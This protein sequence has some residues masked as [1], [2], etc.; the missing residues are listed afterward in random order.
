MDK[1]NDK[2]RSSN[3]LL[4]ALISFLVA[5]ATFVGTTLIKDYREKM[6]VERYA[7]FLE[8]KFEIQIDRKWQNYRDD[9]TFLEEERIDSLKR[10]EGEMVSN[11]ILESS[12]TEAHKGRLNEKYDRL[13]RKKKL[14]CQV[15][16]EDRNLHLE[17]IRKTGILLIAE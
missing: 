1:S 5:L 8:H 11:V 10:I 12:V 9:S 13:L 3:V 14:E 6:R 15:F 16:E 2:A 17:G 4:T 7:N